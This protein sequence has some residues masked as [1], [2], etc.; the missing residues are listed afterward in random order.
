VKI[1]RLA[2]TALLT[3][4][5]ATAAFAQRFNVFGDGTGY[6]PPSKNVP[7]DGRF[8]FA[9]IKYTPCCGYM[10]FYYRGLP[11][12]AHGFVPDPRRGSGQAEA[13]LMKIMDEVTYLHPHTDGGNVFT[14]DDPLLM[15][16]PVAYMVEPG[17]WTMTDKETKGLAAY[18]KKGGFLILD[19]FR[20]DGDPRAG[21]GWANMEANIQRAVPGAQL[22]PL[23]ASM[24]VYDSFFKI[25]SF[26]IIPQA[27][28]REK[29]EF[30]GVFEDND[31]KKRLMVVVNYST[32]ISDFW[33]FSATG[34]R[35]IDES[36]EAYKLG[37]NYIMYGLTH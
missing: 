9:R 13:N 32:D 27:Y 35:P 37:V 33:E 30:F 1:R 18:L 26:D 16:Y 5:V 20:H 28:D 6:E 36:N 24:I 3:F 21:E 22:L 15:H 4:A 23:N 31:P 7:Y 12:W 8:T 29:P 14:F 10:G 2:I 11:A 25:E 34:F 17:F 19:D